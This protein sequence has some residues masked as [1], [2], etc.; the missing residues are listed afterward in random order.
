[1]IGKGFPR[2]SKSR[3]GLLGIA[4][5]SSMITTTIFSHR[6]T[7][8]DIR[9]TESS[10]QLDFKEITEGILSSAAEPDV[11][12]AENAEEF[13]QG[14]DEPAKLDWFAEDQAA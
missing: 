3:L 11:L 5:T 10:E 4:L 6:G 1:M 12:P 8:R 13:A 14:S 2:C 7:K 9:D